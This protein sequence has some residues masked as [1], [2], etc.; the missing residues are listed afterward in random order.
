[1]E[2]CGVWAG[3]L[4]YTWRVGLLLPAWFF[5]LRLLSS[6]QGRTLGMVRVLGAGTAMGYILRVV[7]GCG[8]GG[9]GSGTTLQLRP[10]SCTST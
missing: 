3:S 5:P 10:Q 8:V 4:L 1:M 2:S 9:G 6:Q 7:D